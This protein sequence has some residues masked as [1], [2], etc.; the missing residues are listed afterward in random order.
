MKIDWKIDHNDVAR[1]K[2]LISQQKDNAL[3]QHRLAKNPAKN[4]PKV[5]KDA[6]WSCTIKMRLTSAI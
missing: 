4:K 6:F 3:I 5:R 1:V 2:A